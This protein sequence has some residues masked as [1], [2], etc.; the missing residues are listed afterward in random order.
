MGKSKLKINL[1]RDDEQKGIWQFSSYLSPLPEHFKLSLKE[2]STPVVDFEKNLLLKREDKNPTGSLKDRGMAY[3]VSYAYSQGEKNLVL[4]SSGNAALSAA[5]Y[6][7]LAELKL[8][9]FVAHKIDPQKLAMIKKTPA[10]VYQSRRPLSDSIKFAKQKGFYNLRPSTHA[11]GSEGFQTIAFELAELTPLVE[12][13]FLPVSSGVS[14]LGI[15][16]GFA[17]LGWLPRLHLCQPA[18]CPPLAS[19]F[20]QDYS[21]EKESLA[22]SLVAKYTPLKEEILKIVRESGGRGWV[23][24]NQAIKKAQSALRKKN[25]KTSAEG[26]LALAAVYKAREK[27]FSLENTVCLLTGREY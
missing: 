21:A 18:S 1:K 4:S 2:G 15:A 14:L 12:E 3:L 26:A 9:V 11:F 27:G 17:K 8:H 19:V 16:Q 13:I 7:R 24:E 25:I 23:I 20:D 10:Q 6:C 5:A 22:D